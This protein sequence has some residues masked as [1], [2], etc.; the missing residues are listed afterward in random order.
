MVMERGSHNSV[1][2]RR[3]LYQ[4]TMSISA[5]ESKLPKCLLKHYS[6]CFYGDAFGW[7]NI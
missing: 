2:W 1:R 6:G 5:T 3:G 4:L 7:D